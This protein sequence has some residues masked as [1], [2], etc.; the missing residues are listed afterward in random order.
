LFDSDKDGHIIPSE[1]KVVMDKVGVK[2]DALKLKALIADVD[3][4]HSGTIEF[5]E[6]LIVVQ[7]AKMSEN[8]ELTQT[9]KLQ[10]GMRA[11]KP[12]DIPKE[13]PSLKKTAGGITF[14]HE[15]PQPGGIPDGSE[16][17]VIVKTLAPAPVK[18]TNITG[19]KV[20]ERPP[21]TLP[22]LSC[23]KCASMGGK[24]AGNVDQDC[25]KCKKGQA[26]SELGIHLGYLCHKC[27][28]GPP[29]RKDHCVKCNSPI[30]AEGEKF[31]V[32]L[33]SKHGAPQRCVKCGD[34]YIDD[35]DVKKRR[36]GKGPAVKSS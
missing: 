19:T 16:G 1:L 5:D 3:K 34:V 6:F 10:L 11:P 8:T 7:K 24:I 29:V 9:Y 12:T 27:A 36:A 4:D 35:E 22:A 28:F 32:R 15:R 23:K 25:C 18:I 26:G 17:G 2:C 20:E 14:G 21:D 33:C 30:F 31:E 13:D